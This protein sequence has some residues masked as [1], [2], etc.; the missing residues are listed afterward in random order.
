MKTKLLLSFLAYT[1]FTVSITSAQKK[2]IIKFDTTTFNFGK[3]YEDSGTVSCAFNFFNTGNDNLI[4]SNVKTDNSCIS[5]EWSKEA[6]KSG[7]KG[8]IKVIYNPK[9]RIG[10]F[11]KT[12]TVLSNAS[13]IIKILIVRGEVISLK[14]SYQERFPSKNGNLRFNN[15]NIMFYGMTNYIIKTDT[16]KIYNEW[17]SPMTL[18]ISDVPLHLSF[19][20]EP[21]LLES[22]KEGAIIITYDATKQTNFGRISELLKLQTNDS[23]F[24]EKIIVVFADISEDFSKLTPKDL[25]D[26]PKIFFPKDTIDFGDIKPIDS[27]KYSFEFKNEGK[28]DLIIH[29]LTPS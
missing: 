17:N 5:T 25:E 24:S 1:M 7:K 3:I 18:N 12:I 2:A 4:L 22:G 19:K 15:Y 13:E 20:I 29:N 26:A 10:E 14:K 16:I 27:L 23:L 9:G 21:E 8:L 6:V 28:N 11:S